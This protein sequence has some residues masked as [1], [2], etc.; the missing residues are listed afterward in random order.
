MHAHA[1]GRPERRRVVADH[2]RSRTTARRARGAAGRTPRRR[3]RTRTGSRRR[4]R[5]RRRGDWTGRTARGRAW[6]NLNVRWHSCHSTRGRAPTPHWPACPQTSAIPSAR[7]TPPAPFTPA[8]RAAALTTLAEA[9]ARFRLAVAGLT[10]AQLDTPYRPDGWTVAPGGAS[11]GRQPPQRLP[12]HQV[13]AERRPPDHQ[14]VPRGGV[15]R[16]GRREARRRSPMSLDLLDALHG[17]LGDAA[18]LAS[19]DA[20]WTRTL[21][22]PERGSMTL[23]DVLAIYE[24]HSRHH[25]AHITSL[26][27]RQGW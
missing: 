5:A 1:A 21:L 6:Q 15:G 23:H 11:R 26:R 9:P 3:C 2:R 19:A 17:A 7:S 13:R 27:A 25:T 12:A 22:H 20:Q 8:F 4:R 16:D 10:D 24:W 18:A 14:A